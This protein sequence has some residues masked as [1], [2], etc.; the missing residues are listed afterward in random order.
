MVFRHAPPIVNG[1]VPTLVEAG[2]DLLFQL[3][4]TDLDGL[5]DVLCAVEVVSDNNSVLW[6][7]ALLPVESQDAFGLIQLQWPLPRNLNETTEFLRVH[8]D[9]E[10]SDG[11]T[12]TW[13]STNVSV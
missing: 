5:E 4:I 6:E 2:S 1:T 7:K 12:G 10:D 11:E 3:T 13:A 8:V 9:C